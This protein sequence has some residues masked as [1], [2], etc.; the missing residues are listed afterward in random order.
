M[1]YGSI[2]IR[3]NNQPFSKEHI[4]MHLSETLGELSDDVKVSAQQFYQYV[5]QY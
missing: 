1:E 3:S 5:F 2:L 4:M